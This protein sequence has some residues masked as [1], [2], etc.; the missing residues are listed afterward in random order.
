[1]LINNLMDIGGF[2]P[3]ARAGL[4]AK[5]VIGGFARGA[6]QDVVVIERAFG[7]EFSTLVH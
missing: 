1:M 6:E 4:F 3:L 7:D 5:K 2:R